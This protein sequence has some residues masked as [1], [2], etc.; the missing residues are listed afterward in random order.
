[1]D[2]EKLKVV[3]L[4]KE[5]QQRGLD[6]KGNKAVLVKRL[7]EALDAEDGKGWCK[8]Y[9]VHVIKLPDFTKY[10]SVLLISRC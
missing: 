7:K 6:T 5:L 9:T 1:M 2:P 8:E 3:D 4:R 10:H